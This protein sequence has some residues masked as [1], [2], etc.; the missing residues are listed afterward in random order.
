MRKLL[1]MILILCLVVGVVS[2]ANAEPLTEYPREET[3]YL[4]M[5]MGAL[6]STLNPLA[7]G[8][9][10]WPTGTSIQLLLYETP[11]MMNMLT[12]ELEPLICDSYEIGEDNSITVKVNEKAHFNDGSVLNADDV[13]YSYNLGA[14]YDINWTDYW[15]NIDRVEKVD[16]YTFTIFQKEN[17]V[18]TP[19]VLDSLQIVNVLPSDIWSAI[20]EKAGNDIMKIRDFLNLED[21]VGSGCYMIDNITEGGVYMVR[22]ENYWGVER[23]GKLP[24]A[25]Y[26]ANLI[27]KSNDLLA[28]AFEN[29][30]VDLAQAFIPAINEM[31]QRNPAIG[32]YLNSPPYHVEGGM[33]TAVFNTL[34][35]GLDNAEVRRAIAYSINYDLV[36]Q[37]AMS[38]YTK[39]VTP[40]LALTNGVED[41]Y[42]DK[43]ALEDM[44]WTYDVAKANEILD[45]IGAVPGA[46][47]IRVL[48]DGTRL[49]F[50]IQT[51]YGWT[52]WNAAAEVMSQSCREAGIEII[53]EMPESAVFMSNRQT[54]DYDICL[55]IPGE[56]PRPSQPW[57][58]Y[59]DVMSSEYLEPIGTIAFGNIGRYE[60]AEVTELINLLPT[61][62]DEEE[63]RKVHT[64]INRI[65]L[66][67]VPV[68][69]IMYRPFQFYEFNTTYW[70]GFPTADNGSTVPP[71]HDRGAGLRTFF[72]IEP[73]S[74]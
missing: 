66:T 74:K 18:N 20:E 32:T 1:S 22:D 29:N 34:I 60:N 72:E 9:S 11:F 16:D 33:V 3:I 64:E 4:F 19:N 58:R 43:E 23:F 51:G 30:E 47:G 39:E 14:K 7:A 63:L 25:K 49:S 35:P 70:T 55:N 67:D 44:F 27:Y 36:A 56:N 50:N 59:R 45:N 5:G 48:P 42:I 46:D 15:V 62:N 40:L 13:V 28:V 68:V 21:P 71:M 61:L 8:E 54:G 69:P 6:P 17:A 65:Y 41:K 10:G 73:A 31:S 12:G 53:C 38:G 2:F 57:Y 26:A 24:S 52:D 37:L